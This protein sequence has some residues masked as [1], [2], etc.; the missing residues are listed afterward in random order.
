MRIKNYL[1]R[2]LWAVC[3]IAVVSCVDAELSIDDIST[4]ITVGQGTTTVPLGHLDK[5]TLGDILG[6]TEIE[7]LECDENGNFVF[8]YAGEGD[9]VSIDGITTGFSVPATVSSFSVEYPS[10][11]MGM[12]SIVIN[13]E[14]DVNIDKS[15]FDK[16]VNL[17]HIP[18]L[19]LGGY[20]FYLPDSNLYEL[21]VIKGTFHEEFA[22]D[23][24]HILLDVPQ[25]VQEIVRIFFKNIESGHY[26][27][28]MHLTLDLNDLKGING[29]G[30]LKFNLAIEGGDFRIL[31]SSNAL[32]YEGSD[33]G[34]EY[35]IEEGQEYIDFVIYVESISNTTEFN[36]QHQLDIP[37][38]LICDIEFELE[39]C[40]GSFSLDNLPKIAL[41]ADFE[42]GD[43][44]IIMDG[45][46]NLVEY[47]PE[48]AQIISIG[49]MPDMVKS[50]NRVT[51]QDGARLKL[52]AHGLNWLGE[53]N[54]EAVEVQVTLPHYLILH[55]VPNAEYE[56]NEAGHVITASIA[57]LDRGVEVEVEAFDFGAEGL[58]PDADGNMS[59][60]F[61]P[62]IAAHFAED[63]ELLVSSILHD[64]DIFIETGI[65]EA[66]LS[67]LSVQ[68]AVDY[69]YTVNEQFALS[70]M[71]NLDLEIN[72]VGL[73]P[74]I[75]V[76]LSNPLT[77]EAELEGTITPSVNGETLKDNVVSVGGVVV[78]A[79]KY[80]NGDIEP[81][82]VTLVIADESLRE[83]YSGEDMLF[84]G[85]DVTKLVN[86]RIP[87][88]F[89]ISLGLKV[90]PEVQQTIYVK[91]SFEVEYDYAF[92][93]PLDINDTL[94]IVYR[95]ELADLN[96]TF[97]QLEQYDIK[98]GDVAVIAEICSTLPLALAAEVEML[99]KDGFATTAQVELPED[100]VIDG[101]KD[102][103]T[104]KFSTVRFEL[105]LGEDGS[106]G[107]LAEVDR[108][109]LMLNAMGTANGGAP[110][111]SDQYIS[112]VLKLE[113]K[114]GITIDLR[115]LN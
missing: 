109:N 86:G 59:L 96:A 50:I 47:E 49:G 69:T 91:E 103:V 45:D 99:D 62:H 25:E 61:K 22:Q 17:P 64:G 10:F 97:A 76:S 37:L 114:G 9:K 84:I 113:L 2:L 66:N 100:S 27:A 46:V 31:N 38:K 112:A 51:L 8:S 77:V 74:V 44:D 110:L 89:D 5:K 52:F 34:Q 95:A 7:G 106:V 43:A 6:D 53:E 4:E 24:M 11:D 16:F 26:G 30:K 35:I 33:Y 82:S 85:C 41:N 88:T 19:D 42:Y 54:A 1:C 65:D 115:T 3:A 36:D 75:T 63:K 18:G 104:E 71:E 21:P 72:G 55:S 94:D 101:S 78:P 32:V 102:G 40:P 73:K 87:D 29:G 111:N 23:D 13:A 108:L 39:S 48:E 56:Y 105:K 70:G 12:N 67:I 60:E 28:P 93:M 83:E 15:V 90:D 14:S 81:A 58:K 68:G 20:D 107:Q 98:V 79:A 92:T 80:I 57:D